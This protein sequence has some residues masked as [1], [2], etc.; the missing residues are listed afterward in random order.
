MAVLAARGVDKRF[1]GVV[2][3]HGAEFACEA[4]EIHALLGE[5]G[6]GKS[7]MVKVLCGVQQPD[8]GEI[9]MAARPVTFRG[10]GDAASAG[11]VPV[12]Q[13]LSLVP[14]LSVAENLALGNEPRNRLGLVSGRRMRRDAAEA[15]SRLGFVGIDPGSPVRDLPLADRQLVEIAKAIGRRPSMLIL[16]EAT[17]ALN[18]REVERVFDVVRSM[19]DAGTAVVFISHRMEEV[20]ELCDRA[21]VFRDG[22]HVGTV[23]VRGAPKGQIVEMMVG[24]ALREVFPPRP[25]RAEPSTPLLEVAGLTWGRELRDVSLTIHAGEIV[26]LSGL[27]GQGQGDLLRALFGI[28]ARVSGTVRMGGRPVRLGSPRA[29]MRAGLALVP[30]DR[31]TQALI[32]PLPVRDNLTLP[33]LPRW[34]RGGILS[35]S[36]EAGATTAVRERLAIKTASVATPVRQLSGGN[37]QKVAIAKWLLGETRVFLLHDPTRGIDVGAKQ[38]IYAVMRGLAE[39]GNGVLFFSTELSEIVGLCDRALVMYEGAVV[40]ELR[41]AD[42]TETNLVSAA[43]GFHDGEAGGPASAR[44]PVPVVVPAE[45]SR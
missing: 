26:G 9:T 32:L 20:R 41:G 7:T 1:G 12:F 27:E 38:E 3:L 21:T 36:A 34:S 42:L 14:D 4:G 18:R 24:R 37:Q 11:I 22:T 16:D 17:S 2:A 45:V 10:P 30:E 19:R 23:D 15:L 25:P 40:Q 35:P 5:N 31:K 28:Y 29:A 43:V 13:E 6:A 8:A 39:R 33:T 44:G